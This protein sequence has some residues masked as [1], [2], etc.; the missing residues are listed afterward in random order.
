M[1]F[2]KMEPRGGC[3]VDNNLNVFYSTS[4]ELNVFESNMFINI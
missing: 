3:L 1:N 4:K 2:V